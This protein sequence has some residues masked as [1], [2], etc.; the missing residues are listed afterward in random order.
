MKKAFGTWFRNRKTRKIWTR[1]AAYLLL[2]C[3]AG[4]AGNPT[5][6]GGYEKDSSPGTKTEV[7]LAQIVERQNAGEKMLVLFVQDACSYCESFDEI[8]DEYL[9]NHHIELNVVNLTTE[10]KYNKR[11]DV[12]NVLHTVV[13]G[14][15]QTP[16]LYYIESKE[17][18]YLLDNTSGEYTMESLSQFVE[19]YQ[20][21]AVRKDGDSR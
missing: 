16:S 6:G 13:G 12:K 8:V 11:E 4:C 20:L 2:L 14:L 15:D 5:A 10:E 9:A 7:P 3:L 18:V 17:N 21:D 1:A 19:K